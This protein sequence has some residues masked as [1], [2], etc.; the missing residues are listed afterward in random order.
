MI[1]TIKIAIPNS[2]THQKL[3]KTG[4]SPAGL[5]VRSTGI[6]IQGETRPTIKNISG[7]IDSCHETFFALYKANSMTN[8]KSAKCTKIII[9]QPGDSSI[10]YPKASVDIRLSFPLYP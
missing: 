9:G 1:G 2:N 4:A 3:Y 5:K 6:M 7:S 8:N 10:A